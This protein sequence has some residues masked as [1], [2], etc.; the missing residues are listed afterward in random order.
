VVSPLSRTTWRYRCAAPTDHGRCGQLLTN[1]VCDRV[2]VGIDPDTLCRR[3]MSGP[4]IVHL[5]C[6]HQW[7]RGQGWEPKIERVPWAK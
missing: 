2:E 3:Y 4:T 1:A 6:G 5:P 7:W